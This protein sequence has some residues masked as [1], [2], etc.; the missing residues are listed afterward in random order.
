MNNTATKT[1]LCGCCAGTSVQT[2]QQPS[3]LPGLPAVARRIGTWATFKESFLARLSS[4]DYPALASLKTRSDDDFTIAFLDATAMVLDILTF[5]QER[6]NNESYLGTATQLRSLTE[7][8]RLIGYQPAPG[9]SASTYLA[10]TLQA[11]P[12]QP[13]DPSSVAITIPAGTGVQSVPA[14]GQTP[15]TFETSAAIQAK[16]D[17]NALAIQ[18]TQPWVPVAGDKHMYLAGVATQLNPGD[19]ILVVGQDRIGNATDT[20]WDLLTV[21]KV[22]IDPAN[23]RTRITW[24]GELAA[25]PQAVSKVYALRQKAALFGYN[26]IDPNLLNTSNTSIANQLNSALN[27]TVT[28]TGTVTSGDTLTFA[29]NLNGGAGPTI[30]QAYT[31]AAGNTPSSIATKLS[32]LINA[33]QQFASRGITVQANGPVILV[34]SKPSPGAP[35]VLSPEV[36]GP[37]KSEKMIVYPGLTIYSWQNF[38]L[39][40]TIDLDAIY[41]KIAPQGWVVLISPDASQPTLYQVLSVSSVSR[42]AFGLSA[43]ISRIVPDAQPSPSQYPLR[44]TVA[45]VQS[46]QLAVAAQ[47]LTYPLYG[48]VLDLAELRPDLAGTQVVAISGTRQK[49]AVAE[50]VTNLLF[51][52]DDNPNAAS[53]LNPGDVLTL[54]TPSE[55]PSPLPT[56]DPNTG[57]IPDWKASS[58]TSQITTLSVEDAN[59]RTGTIQ[60]VTINQFI[61]APSGATDPV[62]SEYALVSSLGPVSTPYSHTQL[63]LTSALAKCYDR[64]TTTVNGN[65]GLATHGQ[66]VTEILGSGSAS[67]PNQ[68]FTLKQ[69]PLTFVQAPTPSGRQSTLKVQVNS[70]AW[71]E[72]QTLYEQSGTSQVFATLNQAD[73]TTDVLFGDGVEGALL[74]TGQNNLQASYRIGLGA[75]GNVG[76]GALTTLMDR[77]LGVSGVTNPEAA[78]GGQDAE[79]IDDIRSNAPLTVL[80]L[81]R[82]VSIT[83]YQNY[84][85]TFAG[86]A[87]AYAVWIPSG[88]ARGVFLTVAG[89]DGAVLSPGSETLA[90]LLASLQAYGNPLIPITV[91]SYVETLFQFS[92]DLQYDPSYDQSAVQADVFQAVT[93]AFSFQARTFGQNVSVDEVAATIQG[94]PGVVEGVAG[95][96]AV[97]VTKLW[98][99]TSSTGGDI[100][101]QE[102]LTVSQWNTWL[103]GATTLPRTFSNTPTQLY[104]Y[105]PVA[106]ALSPPFPAEILVLDPSLNPA[107]WGVMS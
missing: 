13:L 51:V 41:Q 24:N 29:V 31:T 67:T 102:S 42:S 27:S 37:A 45:L 2:P 88:P 58:G 85:S 107:S 14:Q 39:S 46:D 73:G 22:T 26:A 3:N 5:Y 25:P 17:W 30:S 7:L 79:S 20:N 104:A 86:I 6:L 103:S 53:L 40:G 81:G 105:L 28:I 61:L 101:S 49:I 48:T 9:V 12:G 72:V 70:V 66:S 64:S 34:S 91:T 4:S 69:S 99:T 43:K 36:S 75:V 52:P 1:S 8:S 55:L 95:V 74:P 63:Q 50:K 33:N 83:D 97:N 89:V 18:T 80:T 57:R 68:S 35:P 71:I 56:F 16:A 11:A 19:T 96:V 84:A 15:Q 10:F 76:A 47:P 93:K 78:E 94:V 65:V 106:S 60:N 82:A 62:V 59:G 54:T 23:N 44:D 87:K 21:Q 92:A 38:Q 90:N 77:P 32:G 98:T 100:S